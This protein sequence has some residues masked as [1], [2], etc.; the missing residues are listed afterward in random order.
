MNEKYHARWYITYAFLISLDVIV[1]SCIFASQH[2]LSMYLASVI[3]SVG[4]KWPCHRPFTFILSCW[5]LPWYMWFANELRQRSA[6]CHKTSTLIVYIIVWEMSKYNV[7]LARNESVSLYCSFVIDKILS[8]NKS[9]K[10][11]TIV[12]IYIFKMKLTCICF[13]F[14]HLITMQCDMC[15]SVTSLRIDFSGVYLETTA[16]YIY[17]K[18]DICL[19]KVT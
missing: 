7:N 14:Y 3:P 6:V 15:M 13:V 5:H 1:L 12:S 9:G 10:W 16:M 18:A 2:A 19:H 11:L 8:V 17:N 4:A